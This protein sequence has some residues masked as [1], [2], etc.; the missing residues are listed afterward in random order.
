MFA[1]IGKGD[2][3]MKEFKH[4]ASLSLALGM[5]IYAVPRLSIGGGWSMP[6]IFAVCWTVLCL[7][8]IAAH[9]HH[10]LGV[11]EETR[12]QLERVELHRKWRFEQ[13]LRGRSRMGR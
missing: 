10:V 6:T 4:L 5:L 12:K 9:L 8:I 2:Y 1:C 3:E 11:D 13:A 7:L